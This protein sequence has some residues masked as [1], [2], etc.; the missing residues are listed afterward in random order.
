MV[1]TLQSSEKIFCLVQNENRASPCPGA[2]SGSPSFSVVICTDN[3]LEYLKRTLSALDYQTYP[4]FEVCVVAGP[5]EDGTRAFLAGQRD[6]LKVAACLERNLSKSRNIGIAMA[7]GDIVAF[8]DD[9]AVPEPE[10]L[11]QLSRSYDE[12]RVGAVGGVVH[13][14]IG[15][16]YQARYVTVNRLGQPRQESRP[17]PELNFPGSPQF[18][19]LLGTNCSFRRNALLEIGGFD[20]TYEYFLD[21]TDVCCRIND[22]GFR[23]VQRPDA[24]VHHKYA[25]STMRDEQRVVRHWYPIIKNRLYFGLR[26]G[27]ERLDVAEIVEA[28]LAEQAFWE[29]DVSEKARAGVFSPEDVERFQSE[30]QSAIE[31]GLRLS[32]DEPRLLTRDTVRR[33]ASQRRDFPRRIPAGGRRVVLYLDPEPACAKDGSGRTEDRDEILS[34]ARRNAVEG[35]DVHVVVRCAEAPSV[36]FGEGLWIYDLGSDTWPGRAGAD[37]ELVKM[38]RRIADR[39]RIDLVFCP[40]HDRELLAGVVEALSDELR[41]ERD[42]P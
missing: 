24:F 32:M 11:A 6:R 31:D 42:R 28:G 22:A 37:E 17:T 1:M 13:D 12:Q 16:D 41:G 25:P 33:H 40:T 9:D 29:Q 15:V 39:R 23:I 10:W 30:A 5:T 34:H 20:E 26:H 14:H 3:R 21:E 8:I 2:V 35:H 36:D 18:P 38:V 27:R 19:H 4:E 7:A